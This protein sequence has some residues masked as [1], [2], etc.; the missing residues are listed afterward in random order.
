M[1]LEHLAARGG[2]RHLDPYLTSHTKNN[3]R[4]IPESNVKSK[5]VSFLGEHTGCYLSD[6]ADLPHLPPQIL[7]NRKTL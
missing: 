5:T 2:K 6:E 7:T 3:L 1:D 4:W